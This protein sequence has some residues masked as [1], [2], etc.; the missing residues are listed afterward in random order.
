MKYQLEGMYTIRKY[1]A[2][3]G[4]LK[5][6]IGPFKNKITNLGKDRAGS[7]SALYNYCY[8]GTGTSPSTFTDTSMGNLKVASTSYTD[9]T[10][11]NSVVPYWHQYSQ[12]YRFAAGVINGNI[13]EVG[14]GWSNTSVGALWSRELIVDSGGNPITLT[15]LA[16]EFLDV[17]YSLRIY[18][19][20]ADFTGSMT[21]N[22][23]VYNYT[24]R[25]ANINTTQVSSNSYRPAPS[26]TQVYSGP[27]ALGPVTGSLTGAVQQGAPSSY[28]IAPY[29]T[30]TYSIDTTSAFAL[31]AG[32]VAGGITGFIVATVDASQ[33]A[34]MYQQWQFVLDK[35]IPKTNQN[36]L[37]ITMR[38]SWDRFAGTIVP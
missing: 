28:T 38:I 16:N 36:T 17:V 18:P 33:L 4:K 14:V 27:V 26:I 20:T 15:V 6:E 1:C 21:I 34:R 9:S 25:T 8:V 13:T 35:P 19:S 3:T 2:L 5:Q 12:T 11:R 7:S 29:V 24:A 32:N 37:G 23:I 10:S 30:G 22:G 31:T